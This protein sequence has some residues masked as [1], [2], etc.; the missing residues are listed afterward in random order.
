MPFIVSTAFLF[1]YLPSYQPALPSPAFPISSPSHHL[2]LFP[3][4]RES[5]I[6]GDAIRDEEIEAVDMVQLLHLGDLEAWNLHRAPILPGF[7]VWGVAVRVED[8]CEG[9][10][11]SKCGRNE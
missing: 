2:L 9:E 4:V 1:Q 6:D 3:D 11:M 10:T 8:L 5:S 7:R